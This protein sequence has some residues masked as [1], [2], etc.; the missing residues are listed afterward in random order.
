MKFHHIGIV[1]K[2]INQSIDNLKKIY[3]VKFISEILFDEN[4]NAK[5]C[6]V[7]T[8]NGICIELISGLK[9]E[10]LISKGINIYHICFEVNDI[11]FEI[12][13]LVHNGVLLISSPKPAPL[14]GNRLVAFLF[15]ET[16][17]IELLEEKT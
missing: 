10:G 16:G 7:E 6:L 12:N 1:S 17:L 11:Y 2:N 4:Q 3:D 14:F 5:V 13:K 8:E 15:T 9:V